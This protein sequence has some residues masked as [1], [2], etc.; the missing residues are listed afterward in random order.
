MEGLIPLVFKALKKKRERSKYQSLS[1]GST[2]SCRFPST[3]NIVEL[4]FEG[5]SHRRTRSDFP[6][7]ASDFR[8]W[9]SS[10][11]P[12][13]MPSGSLREDGG[14]GD[15]KVKIERADD[16]WGQRKAPTQLVKK[17]SI[18][19]FLFSFLLIGNFTF[20][21]RSVLTITNCHFHHFWKSLSPIVYWLVL[22]FR[23]IATIL[24]KICIDLN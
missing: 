12:Q 7:P 19:S 23:S 22:G 10:T 15:W 11:V 16:N 4:S 3:E 8:E 18:F 14:S 21:L 24:K 13:F 6:T 2:R 1:R 9:R 20:G 5:S 17:N